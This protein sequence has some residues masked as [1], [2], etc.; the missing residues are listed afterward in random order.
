MQLSSLHKDCHFLIESHQFC[1][2]K[3]I[4]LL[5]RR[6]GFATTSFHSIPYIKGFIFILMKRYILVCGSI[7]KFHL[8]K[9]YLYK[10]ITYTRSVT[11]MYTCLVEG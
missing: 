5:K 2:T 1:F 4:L 3:K 10:N 6:V 11:K 9:H 8:L 7:I